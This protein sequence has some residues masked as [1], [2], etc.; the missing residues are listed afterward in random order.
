MRLSAERLVLRSFEP[1][2]ARA[3]A[4]YRSDSG[5]ARYQAWETPLSVERAGEVVAGYA[6]DDPGAVGW[7][8]YAISLDG[9]LIGDLGVNLHENRMQAEI[10]FTIAASS[11][12]RGY[13][14]E[15]VA[16]VLRHL[17]VDR[18]LHRVSAE[19][20]PRNE[21][22]ARLL[23]RVGFQR[24]GLRRANTWLRGEW[25]DDLLFGLLAADYSAGQPGVR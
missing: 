3:F 17:F 10:G 13:G 7:F 19:C 23:E 1:G 6:G 24:E 11:Q 18:G 8:Q 4:A 25:T 22:S 12:G 2:D 20:D 16:R 15:A 14:T 9:V 5:V 21:A